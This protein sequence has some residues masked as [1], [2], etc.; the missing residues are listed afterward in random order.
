MVL[1]GGRRSAK[2]PSQYLPGPFA[3]GPYGRGM[4]VLVLAYCVICYPVE[5][6]VF[7]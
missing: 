6:D 7:A 2:R 3:N 1:E 5:V 4:M